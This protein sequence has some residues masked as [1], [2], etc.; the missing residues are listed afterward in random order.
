MVLL[1]LPKI[2]LRTL[3][4]RVF[5]TLQKMTKQKTRRKSK[6]KTTDKIKS[7][8]LKELRGR[9]TENINLGTSDRVG[10]MFPTELYI[11]A[12]RAARSINIPVEELFANICEV[13]LDNMENDDQEHKY[14]TIPT[15]GVLPIN[16]AKEELNGIISDF[17]EEYYG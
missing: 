6:S 14:T 15:W 13:G 5:Y 3:G 12:Q 7:N 1:D 8:S 10:V 16:V 4:L 2:F 17:E 11:R 9:S